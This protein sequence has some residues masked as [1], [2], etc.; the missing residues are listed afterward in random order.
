[1]PLEQSSYDIQAKS[2]SLANRL[3]G[4]ER[5]EDSSLNL[6]RNAGAVVSNA[7]YYRIGLVDCCNGNTAAVG[8]CIDWDVSRS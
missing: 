6:L 7:Y 3:G 5:I 4:K 1:M 8:N 2:G